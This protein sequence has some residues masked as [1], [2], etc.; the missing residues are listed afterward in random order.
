MSVFISQLHIQMKWM[1]IKCYSKVEFSCENRPN[2]RKIQLY[3]SA[4]IITCV[5]VILHSNIAIQMLN[6]IETWFQWRTLSEIANYII[7]K[8]NF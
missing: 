1:K 4:L 3:R 5:N 2:A 7:M 8:I 6:Y